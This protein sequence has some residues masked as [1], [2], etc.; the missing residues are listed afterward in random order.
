MILHDLREQERERA[1]AH[2]GSPLQDDAK[3]GDGRGRVRSGPGGRAALITR[4]A[5]Q[6]FDKVR[7][8]GKGRSMILGVGPRCMALSPRQ[9]ECTRERKRARAA[10]KLVR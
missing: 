1:Q 10:S 8:L 9:A 2:F 6:G 4:R 5:T 7:T 3:T